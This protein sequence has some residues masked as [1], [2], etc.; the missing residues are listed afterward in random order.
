LRNYPKEAPIV[1]A[2]KWIQHPLVK[3]ETCEIVYGDKWTWEKLGGNL[4]ELLGKLQQEFTQMPPVERSEVETAVAQ[5]EQ[6][7]RDVEA[8]RTRPPG[9]QPPPPPSINL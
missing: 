2:Q 4:A 1:Y 8:L 7:Q 6:Y 5:L 9:T 3:V